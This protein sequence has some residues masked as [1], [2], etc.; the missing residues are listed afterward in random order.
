MTKSQFWSLNFKLHN[1]GIDFKRLVKFMILIIQ[2]DN[3]PINY[4]TFF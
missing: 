4:V 3:V 1:F 2:F